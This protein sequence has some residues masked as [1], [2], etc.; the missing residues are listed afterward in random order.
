MWLSNIS[1]PQNPIGLQVIHG[2]NVLEIRE[3]ATDDFGLGGSFVGNETST[4]SLLNN[5]V[6]M[7][8]A[9]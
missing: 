7:N 3:F 8:W 2:Y 5:P 4:E 1:R 9:C 6:A